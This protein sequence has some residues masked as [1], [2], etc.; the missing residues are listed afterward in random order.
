M[1]QK[2]EQK[3]MASNAQVSEQLVERYHKQI[4]QDS[5]VHVARNAVTSHGIIESATNP[6]RVGELQHQFSI[7]LTQGEVCDQKE[8]GRCWMFASL[9]LMRAQI[10]KSLNLKTFE[11]SQSYPLFWDKLEKSNYF[12]EAIIETRSRKVT[13]RL[14]T[15]LLTDPM[16]DGG[17]WDMFVN[18]V[19]KYGVVPKSVMPETACSSSTY[20]MDE[21]L[22]RKLREFARDLRALAAKGSSLTQLRKRKDEMLGE[23]Y[24]M[25]VVCLGEPPARF[26]FEV[27]D[28]DDKFIRHADITPQE[29]FATYVD[30]EL[31]LKNYISVVNGPGSD[32][33]FNRALIVSYLGNVVEGR[34]TKYINLEIDELK[35]VAIAQMKDGHPVWFGCD[36]GQNLSREIGILD[37]YL[38]QTDKLFGTTFGLSKADR[39]SYC[40]GG[41]SHAMTLQGVNLTD[42]DKPTAWRIENTWGKDIHNKGYIT[43]SDEWFNEHMYQVVVHKRYL[44]DKQREIYEHDTPVILKPWDP[45]G[46]LL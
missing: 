24:R 38:V 14:V 37:P 45:M 15:H 46:A 23:I 33:P 36:V 2:T 41:M 10:M 12:L 31:D 13:S 26:N 7:S 25:L 1:G 43:M 22:T 20:E 27:R 17:Q 6:E 11:L 40:D 28:K 21:Y 35:R 42:D 19:Y 16:C 32:K 8:S 44:T 5:C 34:P 29:F 30:K 4:A 18:L 9:N 3:T 39:L